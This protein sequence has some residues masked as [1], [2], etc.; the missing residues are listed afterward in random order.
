MSAG[1]PYASPEW[2]GGV[3]G[4]QGI[5]IETDKTLLTLGRLQSLQ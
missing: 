2:I 3:D 4:T 1:D 5:L